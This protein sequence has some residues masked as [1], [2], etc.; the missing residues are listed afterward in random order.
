MAPNKFLAKLASV[1]AKPVAT[2]AGVRPGAG[3][4]VVRP[5]EEQSFVRPLPVERLWG[6]GPVT[7]QRLHTIG[8]R[9]VADLAAVDIVALRA[10]LGHTPSRSSQRLSPMDATTGRWRATGS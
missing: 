8:I 3:V 6:V 2:A 9:R 7:L 5:G 10:S 4:V 1:E